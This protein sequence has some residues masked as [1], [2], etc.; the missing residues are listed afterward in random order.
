MQNAQGC[1]GMIKHFVNLKAFLLQIR[2]FLLYSISFVVHN[3]RFTIISL[4]FFYEFRADITNFLPFDD[5]FQFI[6]FLA[7]SLGFAFSGL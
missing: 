1:D 2:L 6:L 4:Q 5:F 7:S 3:A